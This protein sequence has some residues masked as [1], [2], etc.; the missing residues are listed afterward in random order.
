M[1]ESFS[2]RIARFPKEIFTMFVYADNA[3]TTRV[4]DKA[5][6]TMLPYFTEQYG[7]PSSAYPFAQEASQALVRSRE[8]IARALNCQPREITFTSG[9]SEADNQVLRSA[10][11]WGKAH[12]KTH[13]VSTAIE[14]HAILH[15]LRVLA[16]E[17]F[18][19]TLLQP[20]Y[21]GRIRL[22]SVLSAIRPDTC[23]VSVM[24][25]NNETGVLQPIEAIG[26]LCQERHILF[27]T[28]AVQYTGHLPLSL[29]D[30]PV[31]LLSASAHKFHGPKGTGFLYSRTIPGFEL[32]SL[33]EGGAQER[34]KRAGTE[35]VAGI[36][37]MA[38]ALTE[39]LEN[40]EGKISHVSQARDLLQ[41]KLQT[42]E[43]VT[44]HGARANRLP[45][46]LNVA[47]AGVSAEALLPILG[48]NGISVSS[49]SACASGSPDPSHVLLAMGIT[50]DE[51][52]SSLRFSLG[53]D[54]TVEQVNYIYEETA[55]AVTRLREMHRI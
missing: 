15:T 14:H 4:S 20:D 36:V 11:A 3:A 19:V 17:G 29:K 2:G 53:E 37:G 31:D 28:D 16:S 51:A 48:M 9:G 24:T 10:A 33:I 54:I 40:L 34:G 13:M 12:G 46:H 18:K 1:K 42:L 22:D 23:L 47:F 39:A 50:S 30:M 32:Q 6:A 43:G 5:L 25:A 38:E 55:K 27:H 7:N 45:G 8:A 26:A 49:G 52:R 35:N 21:Q 41:H 44:I